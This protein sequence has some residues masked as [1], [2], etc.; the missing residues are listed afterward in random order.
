MIATAFALVNLYEMPKNDQP[1][2]HNSHY[3]VNNQQHDLNIHNTTSEAGQSTFA[4]NAANN[5][6]V[7][8]KDGLIFDRTLCYNCQTYGHYA[9]NCNEPNIR[10]TTLVYDGFVMTQTVFKKYSYISKVWILLDTHAT[11]SVFNNKQFLAN[12]LESKETLH[13]MGGIKIHTRLESF[14]IWGLCGTNITQ[15]QISCQGWK[16]ERCVT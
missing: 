11:M 4:Q 1:Q 5:L 15:S 6:P 2:Q 14:Q 3:C 10:G 9:G 8:G 12:I 16:C 7:A 13:A